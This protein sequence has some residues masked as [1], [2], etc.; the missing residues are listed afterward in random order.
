MASTNWKTVVIP[1]F[2]V[3]CRRLTPGPGYLEALV[4][5]NVWSFCPFA[6]VRGAADVTLQTDF[7]S[8]PI[9]RFTETGIET[10]DGNHQELDIIFCATGTL[11]ALSHWNAYL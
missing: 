4:A 3:S 1:S 2:S 6:F 5:D 9:K 11:A 10:E 7:I 8:S